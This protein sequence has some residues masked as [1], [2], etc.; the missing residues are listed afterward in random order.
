MTGAIRV[1]EGREPEP[2]KWTKVGVSERFCLGTTGTMDEVERPDPA[3][4]PDGLWSEA[5]WSLGLVGSALILVLLVSLFGR[6]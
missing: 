3:E 2:E 6:L 5:M 4:E 1:T